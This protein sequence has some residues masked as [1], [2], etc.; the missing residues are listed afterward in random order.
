VTLIREWFSAAELATLALPGMPNTRPGIQDLARREA[1]TRPEYQGK[2]WRK[3]AGRGG[4]IEFHYSLLPTVAQ[5][6]ITMDFA[7]PVDV[8]PRAS[9]KSDLTRT[10]MWSWFDRQTDAKKAKA[11]ERLEAL[12]MV[13]QLYNAGMRKV[14]AVA[15]VAAVRKVAASSIYAWEKSLDGISE[16]DWLPYL[17]PRHVGRMTEVECSPDAW[18]FLK[19][20]YLRLEAPNFLACYR[21]VQ[22]AAEQHGWSLPGARTLERKLASLPPELRTLK[23]EGTEALKRMFPAQQ[24]D[25]GV[26]HALEAV[27]ADG[28]KWD[29]F[30]RWPD[31]EILRPMMVAIQDLYSG[32]ILSWRVDRSANKEAV[33]LAIG[34]MVADWGIPDHCWLDNGRDFASKWITGGTPNRYRFK[35][36]DEDPDGLLTLLG[37]AVHWTTPYHGQSKPIERAFRDLAQDVAKHPKFAGAYTGNTP[38]AKPENYGNSAVPLDVFLA[39][40]GEEIAEHNARIG[41]KSAVAAGRSFDQAFAESYARAPIRKATDEQQRLWLLAAE[42]IGVRRQNG[43]ITLQGNRYWSEF[44][45]AFAGQK[46][47]AR[48]DPQAL[49]QPLHVYRLDGAYLGAA[50]CIEAVGFNNVEAAAAHARKIGTFRKATKALA[51]AEIRLTIQEVAAQMADPVTAPVAPET[52]VVRPVTWGNTARVPMPAEQ[53]EEDE[54]QPDAQR[55][56]LGALAQLS[57]ARRAGGLRLVEEEDADA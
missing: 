15:E 55:R 57:A 52:K 45:L 53:P 11:R 5:V 37:V 26:F 42:A 8:D 40:I 49:H 54:E 19:A 36:K 44:L 47:V 50:P 46:V 12:N 30:V 48:F 7:A 33:R 20:D 35:V 27:N 28:H 32:K 39:T 2:F 21:R 29:V 34:D 13:A 3:R 23:R 18:E 25:R 31:G 10:E 17:A 22:R 14:A 38:M 43:T 6:K 24:R 51:E 4:G 16:A 9:R 56:M 1:W 41:R